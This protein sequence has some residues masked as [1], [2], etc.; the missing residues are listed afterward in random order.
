MKTIELSQGFVA[1]V[2]DIDY[3]L[4]KEFKWRASKDGKTYYA[5]RSVVVDGE[6]RR[7]TTQR[8]HTLIT[9]FD[10]VDHK[11]LNGLDNRR[12]NLRSA[13]GSQNQANKP[14]RSDCSSQFKGVSWYK[15]KMKWRVRIKIDR[16]SHELGYY[17][18]EE[19]AAR[20]YD[21][22]ARILFD[23]YARTNF[24]NAIE[25][26]ALIRTESNGKGIKK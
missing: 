1:L 14:K 12:E 13:T 3:E 5:I 9:G 7:R 20:T 23:E 2:D 24:P 25:A 8:M 15:Q 19:E 17:G 6:L 22:A 16:H 21:A 10:E 11:N 26:S 18:N 4:V